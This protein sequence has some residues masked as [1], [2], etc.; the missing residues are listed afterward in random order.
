MFYFTFY[1]LLDLEY[2]KQYNLITDVDSMKHHRNIKS[3][4]EYEEKISLEIP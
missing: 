2:Q 3:Y 4:H 1:A